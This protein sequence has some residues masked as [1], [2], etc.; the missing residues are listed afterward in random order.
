MRTII[1]AL[2]LA[3]FSPI[4]YAQKGIDLLILAERNFAA[5][6]IAHSTKEAFLQFL[7][8]NGLIFDNGK[9]VNGIQAWNNRQKNPGVLNWRPQYVE[10]STSNDFGYTTGPWTYQPSAKD[11]VVA[12]GRYVTVWHINKVGEWKF[13]VDLGVSNTPQNADSTLKKIETNHSEFQKG[14]E[15]SLV[16]AEREFIK[17][18]ALTVEEKYRKWLSPNFILNRNGLAPTMNT[19]AVYNL[20]HSDPEKIDYTV[21]G[22]GMASSGDLGYVYG[23]TVINNKTDNYLRIW[24]KEKEGW[25]IALEVLRY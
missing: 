19:D 22:S 18:Q 14:S 9:P 13:L 20:L 16:E 7:D 3:F 4:L 24:R 10:I 8:S 5:Y 25:K 12:G 23:T 21:D 6:S 1:I 2:V 11:T 17:D 15:Q